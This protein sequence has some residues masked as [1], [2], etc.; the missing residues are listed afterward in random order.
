MALITSQNILPALL[1]VRVSLA[2]S[3]DVDPTAGNLK[4]ES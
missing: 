2:R 1:V 3:V 4:L